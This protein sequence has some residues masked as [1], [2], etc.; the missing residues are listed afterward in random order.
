MIETESRTFK[1]G[2]R[3]FGVIHF[4][5]RGIAYPTGALHFR[6]RGVEKTRWKHEAKY[7]DQTE[8]HDSGKNAFLDFEQVIHTFTNA[9]IGPG[10]Y[11]FPFEFVLPPWV[12][13]S[14]IYCGDNSTKIRIFYTI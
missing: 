1:A 5:V 10:Q 12:P 13:S 6:L 7:K 2:E 4:E 9:M 8:K 11:T 14:Y 3:I